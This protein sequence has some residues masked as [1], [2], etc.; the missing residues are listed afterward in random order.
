MLLAQRQSWVWPGGCGGRGA[1]W[2]RSTPLPQPSCLFLTLTPGYHDS[3]YDHIQPVTAIATHA[4]AVAYDPADVV[5]TWTDVT[6]SVVQRAVGGWGCSAAEKNYTIF[7][8]ACVPL[9]SAAQ[10]EGGEVEAGGGPERQGRRSTAQR[11][12]QQPSSSWCL[13]A[14]QQLVCFDAPV[15][16][17][18][19]PRH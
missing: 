4:P 17:I 7:E 3:A 12:W 11:C 19:A 2:Q 9:V 15:A 16:A 1:G 8:G 6:T 5:S 18:S 10:G 14:Q 13:P